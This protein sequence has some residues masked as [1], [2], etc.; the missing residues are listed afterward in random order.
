MKVLFAVN[1]EKVSEAIIRKYQAMYKEII[2]WKNV[3]YFNA[4][5]KE[6]QRDKTYDRIV[7]GEDL[8]PYTN[9]NYEVIDNFLFDKLDNI[10]D[11]AT[12]ADG[13]D[14][15]II[16]IATERRSKGNPLIIKLFGIGIY[17]VLI[18]ADRSY[19]NVCKL[20]GK[21]RTKKE[22]K[23]Y[24]GIDSDDVEEYQSMSPD[25]VP[26][27]EMANIL[28]HYKRL[29]KDE[30]LYVKSFDEIAAQYTDSQLKII[31]AK[32]PLN[33]KAVLEE[34]SDR[35]QQVMIGSVKNQIKNLREA[36]AKKITMKNISTSK[37]ANKIGLINEQ[38]EKSKLTRPVVI[39]SSVNLNNVSKVYK[40]SKMPEMEEK[41]PD[42][43]I[44]DDS[45]K[46]E[47]E[48][49]EEV[50]RGRGR[51]KK[52]QSDIFVEEPIEQIEQQ[53][54]PST[55]PELNN[56]SE[57]E[58]EQPKR[59]RG[60]PKK[61]QTEMQDTVNLFDMAEQNADNINKAEE[62]PNLFD[63]PEIDDTDVP[64]MIEK[65]PEML[66][67]FDDEPV[68]PT[69]IQQ[70]QPISNNLVN[71]NSIVYTN[72]VVNS[73]QERANRAPAREISSLIAQ[74]QKIVSFVG[75]S[76][77][78]TSFLVNN[79]AT[80]LSQRG[81]KTALLDLT[82]NQNSY[83]IYNMNDDS[84]RN[85]AYKCAENLRNGIIDGINVN[86]NFSVF[87][88]VPGEENNFE[89]YSNILATLLKE[90]SVVLL[91]C[92]FNTNENYF[93]NSS[94]IYLVQTYDI[95]TIQPLTAFLNELQHKGILKE[96]KLRIIINKTLKLKGLTDEMIVGGIS[97]Y[98]DPASTYQNVLFHKANVKYLSIPFE[99]Q[100][101]AKYL[102]RL[103][104]CNVSLNGYSKYFIDALTRLADMVYPLI[105]NNSYRPSNDYNNYGNRNTKQQTGFRNMNDTLNKMRQ[106]Y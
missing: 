12:K 14:I 43:N 72:N 28:K 76:K 1:N 81:I 46:L 79:L 106:K 49:I 94:E 100:T 67:G 8:E 24:Y 99:E 57:P 85:K 44:E 73:L 42:P 71:D 11:E 18:G 26:E 101:Y 29:G 32:L 13:S 96:E 90:Y 65:E 20:I 5:I 60:R 97:C 51:P 64:K 58:V 66:P 19:E 78:G 2:S 7:I 40:G 88:S 30:S 103:V 25:S 16:F 77:N 59:G 82:Q 33:V 45:I 86:K 61:T 3:Y 75:T 9:N 74:N 17:N 39:P 80:L 91:D 84:L 56:V 31:A 50:K 70:E 68:A 22:A 41:M 6:L 93:A 95:L 52:T 35:Y 89:D 87:T 10:S 55:E 104:D 102:E 38:L 62:V 92:D 83:Y 37:G 98:N 53:G 27:E 48:E 34:K 105:A 47:N 4:I 21:P 15:P 63:M 54:L 23:I 69:K 36:E